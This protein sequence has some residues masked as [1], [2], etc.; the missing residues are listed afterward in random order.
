M[1]DIDQPTAAQSEPADA[2]AVDSPATPTMIDDDNGIA[3][4]DNP[5]LRREL[6]ERVQGAKVVV[7]LTVWLGLLIGILVLAYQGSVAINNGFGLDVASIGRVGRQI[8]EWVLFGM[9][10]LMLFLVPGLT[11]GTITGERERQTLVPLQMT[12]MRP[13]DIIVGKLA[14]ALAFLGL[15]IVAASPLLAVSFLVGGV[16]IF[17]MVRGLLMLAFT[18]VVLGS[19]CVAMSARLR[20]TSAATVACYGMTFLFSIGSFLLLIAWA[21]MLAVGNNGANDPPAELLSIS[22]FA[23]VAD[24]LPRS[25]GVGFIGETI[26]PFGGL[27]GIIDELGGVQREFDEFGRELPGDDRGPRIWIYYTV[28]GVVLTIFSLRSAANSITTPADTER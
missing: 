6:I 23:A 2:N 21:I 3:L 14:A 5:V 9:L 22:P 17:D 24:V 8:F 27:R 16:S 11:A 28:V 10:I 7:M 12:L 19:V 20:R 26:S 4:R 1:S 13:R 25:Q 15:L 18:G